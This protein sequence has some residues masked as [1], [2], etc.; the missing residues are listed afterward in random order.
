MSG[1]SMVA[2]RYAGA[3]LSLANEQHCADAVHQDLLGFQKVWESEAEVRAFLTNPVL[4]PLKKMPFFTAAFSSA[5]QPLTFQFFE[6]LLKGRRTNILG[7]VGPAFDVLYRR[8]MGIVRVMV[9]TPAPLNEAAKARITQ[10]V[11]ASDVYKGG[12]Q[13]DLQIRI[14]ASLIGGLVVRVEDQQW[15]ASMKSALESFKRK[16]NDNPY[17]AEY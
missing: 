10:M 13:I 6:K 15:D 16:F 2:S 1:L 12:K 7:E 14:D 9:S 3:L 5:F 8:Q 11:Q 17:I 4:A